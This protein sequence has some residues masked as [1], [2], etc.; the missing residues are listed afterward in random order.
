MKDENTT[1][2]NGSMNNEETQLDD[3]Q[4]RTETQ[5]GTDNKANG[6]RAKWV[7]IAGSAGS[8]LLLGAASTMLMS[9]ASANEETGQ[10][11]NINDETGTV[12]AADT[13]TVENVSFATDITDDMSFSEAFAAARH[14]LGPGG[15]FEWHGNVYSTYYAEEWNGMT[16]AQ[17]AEHSSHIMHAH[18]SYHAEHQNTAEV[19]AVDDSQAHATAHDTPHTT[20][21]PDDGG[22]ISATAGTPDN[23]SWDISQNEA[24]DTGTTQTDDIAQPDVTATDDGIEVEVIGIGH[25]DATG[26]NVVSM[27]VDGHDA[28]LVDVDNN[29]TMDALIV[30]LN[31]DGIVAE[32]EIVDVSDQGLTIDQFGGIDNPTGDL[33][34]D[35]NDLPDYTNDANIDNYYA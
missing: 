27:T 14:E 22:D 30:D 8:G 26:A 35:N 15:A 2:D 4:S 32:N 5:Q 6:G 31:D 33:Y 3:R 10:E 28:I 23:T 29:N 17:Q 13:I 21:A 7:H 11:E 19:V 20:T 24:H 25:D 34:A 1:F 18:S 12:G 16:E 9:A